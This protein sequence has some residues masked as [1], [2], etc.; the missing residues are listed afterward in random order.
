M[1]SAIPLRVDYNTINVL[2]LYALK[3]IF[4]FLREQNYHYMSIYYTILYNIPLYRSIFSVLL[5]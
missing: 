1:Y 5:L 2:Y 3:G 4:R